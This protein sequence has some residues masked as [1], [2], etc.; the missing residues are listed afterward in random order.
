ME[1]RKYNRFFAAI[2]LLLI[3]FALLPLHASA[4]AVND[5]GGW[6]YDD[7][8]YGYQGNNYDEYKNEET[9]YRAVIK[10][11]AGY[12]KESE[13]SRLLE[14]MKP[15]TEYSNVL[16][17]TDENNVYCT[18]SYSE[19]LC[20]RALKQEFGANAD[21]VVYLV[22]NEYD[23]IWATGATYDVIDKDKAYIITDNVYRYSADERYYTGAAEAFK[24]IN[25]V[26]NG[27]KIAQPMRY[28]CNGLMALFIAFMINFIIVDSKSKLKRASNSEM[29]EG[30]VR[31]LQKSMPDVRHTGTTRTYSPRSSGSGGGHG[32]GGHG[33]GGHG[34]GGGHSH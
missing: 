15:I 16:Y 30:S 32:G 22:D 21:A 29:I 18:E 6:S 20:Q 13:V 4:S 23:Y 25:D 34:G 11:N 3:S 14:K 17:L 31:M 1:C 27:R 26:L 19:S 10:D 33:G 8:D 5:L 2:I 24:E 12:L 28:I 9:G 7:D